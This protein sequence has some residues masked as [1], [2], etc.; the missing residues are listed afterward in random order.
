MSIVSLSYLLWAHM[1]AEFFCVCF[2]LWAVAQHL[3]SKREKRRGENL[4]IY[5][6]FCSC[7][8][9]RHGLGCA[10]RGVSGRKGATFGRSRLSLPPCDRQDRQHGRGVTG[11]AYATSALAL[12]L[13]LPGERGVTPCRVTA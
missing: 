11:G 1:C 5:T 4:E 9:Y 6:I 3:G 7:C 13:S 2:T 10:D 8:G 12:W